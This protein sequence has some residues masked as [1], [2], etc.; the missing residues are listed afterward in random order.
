MFFQIFFSEISKNR[1]VKLLYDTSKMFFVHI[2]NSNIAVAAFLNNELVKININKKICKNPLTNRTNYSKIILLLK[3][4]DFIRHSLGSL[5]Q[6]GEHLPY[7]QRVTGSSPVTS[8]I[9]KK[10]FS[11]RCS[12]RQMSEISGVGRKSAESGPVVQLV[13]TL[14]CHGRGHEFESRSDRHCGFS[15]SGRAPPCQGGGSEFEPRNPLH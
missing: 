13:R 11:V 15:S 10:P 1:F 14:P 2:D 9:G 6:L 5:A 3:L 4:N 8:T 7:K 12:N